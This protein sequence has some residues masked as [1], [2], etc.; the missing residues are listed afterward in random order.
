MY[1]EFA[2]NDCETNVSIVPLKPKHVAKHSTLVNMFPIP[3]AAI[4]CESVEYCPIKKI[5]Y[6]CTMKKNTLE[7]M[8]GTD[9]FTTSITEV[10]QGKT[11]FV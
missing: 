4:S 1:L 9:A 7:R 3:T 8:V 6:I 5:F 10:V 2:P 11:L